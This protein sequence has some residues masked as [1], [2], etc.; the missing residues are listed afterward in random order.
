[1]INRI[2]RMTFREDYVSDF[3][4]LFEENKQAIRNQQGCL[5]LELWR[6]ANHPNSFTTY[7]KW[8]QEEDLDRYRN[9]DLFKAVWKRTKIGFSES[10]RAN[11]Y[12]SIAQIF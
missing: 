10:P 11:S 2:V 7:S 12:K 8:E 4:E 1:M 6:D 3:L 9:S 5:Y